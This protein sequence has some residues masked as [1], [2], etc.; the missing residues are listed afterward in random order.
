[1]K[2][3]RWLEQL[4]YEERLREFGLFI[5]EKRKLLGDF[6]EA[7][8]YLKESYK[9]DGNVLSTWESSDRTRGNGFKQEEGRL[10]LNI[11][12]KFFAVRV[13]RNPHHVAQ[14]SC[15]CPIRRSV[16]GQVRWG[17]E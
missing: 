2:M 12:K 7:F 13:M 5:L 14:K 10:R 8:Q 17:F 11:R 1:M 9:K 16:Q 3:I 4:S 15:G 6:I